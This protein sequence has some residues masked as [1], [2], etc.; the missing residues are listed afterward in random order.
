[1]ADKSN[2]WP[3]NAEGRFFVDRNCVACDAC[4]ACAPENFTMHDDGHSVLVKQP[5]TPEEEAACQE[6]IKGCPV[7]AI[8]EESAADQLAPRKAG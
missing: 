8:G 5:A 4:C 3:E 2:A 1:M 7:D 6:A